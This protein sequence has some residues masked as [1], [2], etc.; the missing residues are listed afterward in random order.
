[1]AA[2]TQKKSEQKYHLDVEDFIPYA[3]HYD[4][5]TIITKNGEL[6]EVIKITGFNFETIREVNSEHSPLRAII[7]DSIMR[8]VGS[9][10]VAVWIHTMRRKRN[11]AMSEN[12]KETFCKELNQKWVQKNNW[13]SQYI[14]EL[15]IT[16]LGE[17]EKLD[18]TDPRIIL[19]SLRPKTELKKRKEALTRSAEKLDKVTR[20]VMKDLE[21]FG[22]K[23]LTVYQKDG[24]YY[25]EILGF[26]SKLMNMREQELPLE[27][28][29][30]SQLIPTNK[31]IFQ[32]NVVQ[33]EGRD[34]KH[35]GAILSVKEYQ[36]VTTAEIDKFLQLPVQFM[37]S[38]SFDFVTKKEALQA[39]QDQKK[40]YEL[41]GSKFMADIS[42]VSDIISGN[43]SPTAY[44]KHQ[45]VIT[46]LEDTVKDMQKA[47]SVVVDAL[48]ELGVVFVREDL[49]LEYCYWS[50]MP[51]NFDFLKRQSYIPTNKIGGYASLYNFPAGKM[52]DNHWGKAVTVFRTQNNTPYFFNFHYGINGH[53]A[54]IGPVK[55]GKTVLLNFLIS[56]AQK[57]NGR[58][59][60]FEREE[61]NEIFVNSIGGKYHKINTLIN[62][63]TLYL[64]PLLLPDEPENRRFLVE[65]LEYLIE[66][67]DENGNNIQNYIPISKEDL[68][69]VKKA[70]EVNYSS[71][72]EERMLSFLIPKIWGHDKNLNPTTRRLGHWYMDGKYAKYFDSGIDNI[73]TKSLVT[74]FNFSNIIGNHSVAIPM[75]TYLLHR[76]EQLM[77]VD[78]PTIIVLEEAWEMIDNPALAPRIEAWLERITEKNG[79]VIFSTEAPEIAEKS[80]VTKK[81][82]ANVATKMYLPNNEA[83]ENYKYAFG[84]T[85]DEFNAIKTLDKNSRQFLFK[86]GDDS[87]ICRV[88]FDGMLRELSVLSADLKRVSVMEAAIKAKGQKPEN[89]LPEYYRMLGV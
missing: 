54:L 36:E 72:K 58:T 12:L 21:K 17:G 52:N 5:D 34:E 50:Q 66:F 44:G 16:F 33:V 24:I 82:M 55:S 83:S 20:K 60:Y 69:L 22:A 48:R 23:K 64:N 47:L 4:E 51:G 71:P 78:T 6:M 8:N 59:I 81:V 56:E 13:D 7:R 19:D 38:E 2:N 76:A 31:V 39:Y 41:S 63:G 67:T 45:I 89:W 26:I 84:L 37:V 25:S 29:D 9:D 75:I 42:G 61:D 86:R 68:D 15:Y 11:I 30:L 80:A 65:W 85:D 46:I 57:Y 27:P 74:A 32:Y 40:I 88:N 77:H 87:V 53:T 49:F 79:I 10:E 35:F 1:M 18:I 62:Q 3:A 73:D 14:N 70:V 43:D 28:I